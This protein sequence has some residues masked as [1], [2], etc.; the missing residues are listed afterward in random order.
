MTA[1]DSKSYLPYLKR[2]VDQYNKIYHH[3]INKKFINADDSALTEQIKTNLQATKIKVNDKVRIT[4][5]KN[6]F[7]K[8]SL[9]TGQG[10]YLLSILFSKL[11]LEL[12]RLKI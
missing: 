1:N 2:L 5:Y 12:T 9:K 6:I 8:D 4:K 3:P 10:K 7:S 11:I